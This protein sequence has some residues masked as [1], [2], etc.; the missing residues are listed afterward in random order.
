MLRDRWAVL[1]LGLALLEGA[2]LLAFLTYFPPVLEGGG[3]SPTVAGAV[4]SGRSSS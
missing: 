4:V 2:A 3:L 1:V